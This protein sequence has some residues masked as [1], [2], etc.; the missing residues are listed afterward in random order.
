M[1]EGA[2]LIKGP[3]GPLAIDTPAS[4]PLLLTP[5]QPRRIELEIAGVNKIQY[6]Y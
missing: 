1:F 2:H 3:Q 4:P 5:I 6:Y